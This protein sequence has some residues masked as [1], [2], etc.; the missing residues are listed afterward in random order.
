MPIKRT[1]LCAALAALTATAA[2]ADD[3]RW[4]IPLSFPSELPVLGDMA[5]YLAKT[6]ESVSGGSIRFRLE[7]PGKI[8]PALGVLEAV[9]AGKLE[10]GYIWIGYDTGI[11][12]AASII[13]GLP[14]GMEP[15]EYDA[16]LYEAGGREIVDGIYAPHNIK[17]IPCGTVGA[18]TAGWFRKPFESVDDLKGLKIRFAGVGGSVVQ[19]LGA[20]VTVLPGSELYQALDK[21]AID[22]TEFSMPSID[23][24]L[25]FYQIAKYNY[26]PGWHQLIA[27]HYLVVNLD[28]WN[29]LD[30]VQRAQIET[31][32][33][34]TN[35][36]GITFGEGQ[37]GPTLA[38]FEKEG[39]NIGE[40]PEPL[41]LE[42]RE[43]S[44][45]VI[46]EQ[47]DSDPGYAKIYNSMAKFMSQYSRWKRLAYLPRDFDSIFDVLPAQDD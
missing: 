8:V 10:A 29:D 30:D 14:F 11:V 6:V 45:K 41:L 44:K 23:D 33:M 4:R 21:G 46:Q 38:K 26:F 3:I 40:I 25:G 15:W 12:P 31:S 9:K 18:E 24:R 28:T 5:K 22:A 13:G 17:P 27:A 20:S 34:A 43:A 42:L 1:L 47:I 37:Q 16:W 39:V 2:H 36:K 19:S 35:A 7:E 32:C